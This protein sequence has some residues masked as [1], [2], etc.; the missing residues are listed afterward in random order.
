MAF[1]ATTMGKFVLLVVVVVGA[2]VLAGLTVGLPLSMASRGSDD[3][4]QL[5]HSE[6]AG[7]FELEEALINQ[8]DLPAW[9]EGSDSLRDLGILDFGW[10]GKELELTGSEGGSQARA[11]LDPFFKGG[12]AFVLSEAAQMDDVDAA[13]RYME[14]ITS[15]LAS[16]EDWY[17]EDDN[18]YLL[19][20]ENRDPPVDAY[21]SRGVSVEGEQIQR[22]VSFFQVGDVVVALQYVGPA[23]PPAGL[24]E[25]LEKKVLARVSPEDFPDLAEQVSGLEEPPE[26]S[27]ATTQ[28]TTA[29]GGSADESGANG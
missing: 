9:Q 23:D 24:M 17:D 7:T 21:I 20:V 11:F 13:R 2:G 26:D 3:V 10:C 4:V 19:E 28:T 14:D 12:T 18:H 1:F 15:A 22:A 29:G 16:C 27:P 5:D 6:L 8:N 25:S